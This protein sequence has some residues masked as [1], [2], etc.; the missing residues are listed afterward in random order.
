VISDNCQQWR[1]MAW[2]WNMWSFVSLSVMQ[3][4]H[5]GSYREERLWRVSP[6]GKSLKH[7]LT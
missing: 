7:N 2:H 6:V 5:R 4:G 3:A 1:E